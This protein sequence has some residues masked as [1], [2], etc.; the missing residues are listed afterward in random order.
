MLI[1]AV[2]RMPQFDFNILPIIAS[3]TLQLEELLCSTAF[4]RYLYH[5]CVCGDF[6][7][8]VAGEA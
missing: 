3:F 4:R 2:H 6:L 8:R 5:V 1:F 7:K